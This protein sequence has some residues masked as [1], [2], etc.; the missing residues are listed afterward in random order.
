M[1]EQIEYYIYKVHYSTTQKH[2]ESVLTTTSLSRKDDTEKTRET[3]IRDIK[4]Y[5]KIGKAIYTAPPDN[6]GLKKGGKV[7]I[8][9]LNGKEYIKTVPD[10]K[11]EDN[12]DE[13]PTY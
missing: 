9:H 2:I 1:A 3:V 12:L 7:I 10:K 13:L 11:T 8:E 6:G 4:A 5:E